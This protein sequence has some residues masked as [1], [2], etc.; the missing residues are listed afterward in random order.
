M[1]IWYNSYSLCF[2]ARPRGGTHRVLRRYSDFYRL[3]KA[4]HWSRGFP[5]K[6]WFGCEGA[7]LE[8]R[9]QRLEKWLSSLLLHYQHGVPSH[10][11]KVFHDFL[12]QNSFAAPLPAFSITVPSGAKP[13]QELT[14]RSP[15]GVQ[16]RIQVPEGMGSLLT[17]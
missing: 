9:R 12:Y 6:L 5:S 7:R 4:V 1:P 3:R 15:E 2:C 16:L 17:I 13:G 11:A 8:L 14:V 10:L